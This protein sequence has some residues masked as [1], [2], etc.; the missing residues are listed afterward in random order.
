MEGLLA[1]VAMVS[2]VARRTLLALA[3][4]L[5]VIALLDWA[6]RERRLNPFGTIARFMRRWVDPL[7]APLE[8]HVL[9]FGGRPSAA[10]L[11]ALGVVVVG[12]LLLLALIDF[13]GDQ[14]VRSSAAIDAG[15]RGV[16]ALVV[17]W[18]FALLRLALLVRVLS[19]WLPVSPYSPWIRWSYVLTEWLLGP[20]RRVIPNLGPID[21]T[22][23]AAYFALVLLE[24]AVLA[25]I[26]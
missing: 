23:I 18:G 4:V 24:P 22:P 7:L 20:L 15:P 3:L 11:W 17:L 10:P 12:G 9:R 16:I 26:R 5:A 19:S 1:G 25:L 21:I 14:V 13:V 6:V 2:L 8:K